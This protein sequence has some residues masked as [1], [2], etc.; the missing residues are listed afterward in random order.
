[1]EVKN[2]LKPY[3]LMLSKKKKSYT[4]LEMINNTAELLKKHF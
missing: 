3:S 2:D 1:M 4:V